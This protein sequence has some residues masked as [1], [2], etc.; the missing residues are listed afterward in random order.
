MLNWRERFSAYHW[1]IPNFLD[2]ICQFLQMEFLWIHDRSET[3]IEKPTKNTILNK[4]QEK[5]GPESLRVWRLRE[6]IQP[7][8]QVEVARDVAHDGNNSVFRVRH[9]VRP[10]IQSERAHEN[11]RRWEAIYVLRLWQAVLLEWCVKESCTDTFRHQTLRLQSS[12]RSNSDGR[13]ASTY[14]WGKHDTWH[15]R[16][17][18]TWH[19]THEETHLD[20]REKKVSEVRVVILF[21]RIFRGFKKKLIGPFIL[22][23][24]SSC[25]TLHLHNTLLCLSFDLALDM[26]NMVWWHCHYG[27]PLQN[28]IQTQKIKSCQ[29]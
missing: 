12:V 13:T 16:K 8:E 21:Q 10:A 29:V 5:E 17:H 2:S 23:K 25:W 20:G 18:D 24:V 11:S 3:S 26:N 6:T 9:T 22:L 1:E 28:G 4:T 7:S 15:M 19:I 14:T 27:A